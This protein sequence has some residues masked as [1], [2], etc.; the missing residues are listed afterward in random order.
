MSH[1]HSPD[2][3]SAGAKL[4]GLGFNVFGIAVA[5][6]AAFW[7]LAFLFG[8]YSAA[9]PKPA[10]STAEAT[11]PTAAPAEAAPASPAAA[12]APATV[13][14]AAPAPTAASGSALPGFAEGQTLFTTICA[15]CHQPTGLG[16]P[17]MFPP[18]A[19]SD[20]V[21]AP[22]TERLIRIVVHG[23]QGPINVNG[24]PF[25]SLAP[26]MPPQ[27]ALPDKQIAAVL[28]Y[29]RNAFGN[30]GSAVTPEQVK[31]VRDAEKDRVA[32]WDEASLLKVPVTGAQP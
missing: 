12:P 6:F 16:L 26:I 3:E 5:G 27:G 21:T 32:M 4:A 13:A 19:G 25:A 29:A 8:G 18:L 31:A 14:P 22:G 9:R 15:V 17:N 7:G 2:E 10:P 11:P 28:T 23:F 24:K 1:H 20:W 30:K